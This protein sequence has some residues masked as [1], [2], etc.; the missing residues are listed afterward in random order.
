MGVPY[1]VMG[2]SLPMVSGAFFGASFILKK[3]VFRQA[4]K[5]GTRTSSL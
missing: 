3:K 2:L 4:G 1:N 5:P